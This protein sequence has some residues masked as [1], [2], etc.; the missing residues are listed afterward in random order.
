MSRENGLE[1]GRVLRSGAG[2]YDVEVAPVD[3][4]APVCCAVI[5]NMLA[6]HLGV[7]NCS[8]PPEGSLVVFVRDSVDGNFGV[9][10]G[11]VP[12][13]LSP[14][15]ST[16]KVEGEYVVP[17]GG[18]SGL[19]SESQAKAIGKTER[20]TTRIL[21]Q[22]RL[23]DTMPGDSVEANDDGVMTGLLQFLTFLKAS[24][25]AKVECFVMDDLVRLV[26]GHFQHFSP[27][28]EQHI[29]NDEGRLTMEM[30]MAAHQPE[31]FGMEEYKPVFTLKDSQPD[32][33]NFTTGSEVPG[34]DK[35]EIRDI[36]E[37][38]QLLTGYLG[39]FIHMI[40]CNP[41][42]ELRNR[43]GKPKHEGLLDQQYTES[44]SVVTKFAED[45]IFSR[46]DRIP[47]PVKMKEPWDP[48]GNS[49]LKDLTAVAPS[50]P[51]QH[52]QQSPWSMS[53]LIREQMA[54]ITKQNIARMTNLDKDWYVPEEADAPLP[55]NTYDRIERADSDYAN[56][57]NRRSYFGFLRDGSFLIRDAWGGEIY[58]R[59]GS[60]ILSFPAEVQIRSGKSTI[61]LAGHDLV[62]KAAGS[63]DMSS[64]NG[65]VRAKA[66]GSL[67]LVA[68]L[69]GILIQSMSRHEADKD[70]KVHYK[71]MKGEDV[72]SGGI[73]LRADNDR[74]FIWG[75]VVHVAANLQI[76]LETLMAP[77]LK[78]GKMLKETSKDKIGR[79]VISCRNLVNRCLNYD[80]L[81]GKSSGMTWK[82]RTGGEDSNNVTLDILV[83]NARM[84][85]SVDQGF[86]VYTNCAASEGGSGEMQ[87]YRPI[88]DPISKEPGSNAP[89]VYTNNKNWF[90]T[91]GKYFYGRDWLEYR[92][93]WPYSVKDGAPVTTDNTRWW[94]EFTFRT[95]AQYGT[96]KPPEMKFAP[97]DVTKP[98]GEEVIND[99]MK[100][101]KQFYIYQ[102]PW[103]YMYGQDK[104]MVA[105]GEEF[106]NGSA[107]WPGYGW[108]PKGDKIFV[109]LEEEKNVDYYGISK[110]RKDLVNE[111]KGLKTTTMDGYT[112]MAHGAQHPIGTQ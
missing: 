11:C 77:V 38:F 41:E 98:G 100:W 23:F 17:S 53:L 104:D 2:T 16:A 3:G 28:G 8:L 20:T 51:Y 69:K 105:W 101:N 32:K 63:I 60:C 30:R 73:V 25:R 68:A 97:T 72:R 89:S 96:D 7:Q 24:E 37:R 85:T 21:Q 102:S 44:G 103:Q 81:I 6:G 36:K 22:G 54:W 111:P 106:I 26:S 46:T 59:G 19:E 80:V 35:P 92:P 112:V 39:N 82:T 76:F 14:D 34:G 75:H 47:V 79:V 1:Y 87:R 52:S 70:G 110:K 33:D 78:A 93:Y 99:A 45:V 42:K 4:D 83:N 55:G 49:K 74:I 94:T 109:T 91:F 65:D 108:G 57:I 62:Q 71:D 13:D 64:T 50:V 88:Q 12:G 86:N 48:D 29:Y 18:A 90:E 67:Q 10:F 58:M 61:V 40:I 84:W 15:V 107:P 5:V 56:S 66:H 27:M 31:L 95:V 43:G 9:I